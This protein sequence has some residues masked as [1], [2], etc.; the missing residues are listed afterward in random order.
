MEAVIKWELKP[1]IEVKEDK[2]KEVMNCGIDNAYPTRME[3]V[4]NGS[5]T[6]KQCATMYSRFLAGSG[7][8]DESLNELVVGKDITGYK[9]VTAVDLLNSITKQISYYGGVWLYRKLNLDFKTTGLS[10][11]DFKNT[12]FGKLDDQDY[13]GKILYYDNWDKS[14]S[15]KF[16]EDGIIKYYAYNE[17]AKVIAEQIKASKGFKNYKGQVYYHFMDGTYIYPLSPIDVAQH[18]ADTENMIQLFKNGELRR[19]FFAK[20][21]LT[22]MKFESEDKKRD[23]FRM[24][25]S[26]Q[27]AEEGGS[28]LLSEGAFTNNDGTVVPP[29]DLKEI[30]QN[31]NSNLFREYEDSCS[32]NIRKCFN[33]IPPVLIDYQ[34]G[35]LGG[36]SGESITQATEFYNAQTRQDRMAVS[37]IFRKLFKVWKDE[38][39]VNRDWTIKPLSLYGDNS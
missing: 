12:R 27:G 36:T 14:K 18:D 28:I 6:A 2:R 38:N 1:R 3:R 16:E 8:V 20:Y 32:N 22:Y 25:R 7:F 10:V 21:M 13:A 34:E 24:L 35:K 23:F 29:F 11:F 4:I 9:D 31:I 39:F 15:S 33:N 30:K 19:G 17:D 5:V 26:F 37:G